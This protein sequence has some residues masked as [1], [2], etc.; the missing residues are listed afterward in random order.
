MGQEKKYKANIKKFEEILKDMPF[1]KS[2]FDKNIKVQGCA[3]RVF[4]Y[5][6]LGEKN[7]Q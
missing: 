7:I 4:S 1:K 6:S 5:L 3:N 2:D